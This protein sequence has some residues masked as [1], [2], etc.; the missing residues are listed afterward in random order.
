MPLWPGSV[1]LFSRSRQC[2]EDACWRGQVLWSWS[3]S[4]SLARILVFTGGVPLALPCLRS[5]LSQPQGL[6]QS[7]LCLSLGRVCKSFSQTPGASAE[8]RRQLAEPGAFSGARQ[9][10]KN[11]GISRRCSCGRTN[12]AGRWVACLLEALL[13]EVGLFQEP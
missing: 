1:V 3:W 4:H 5:L 2:G 10:E 6:V 11:E 13:C 9:H 12:R 7:W 8:L